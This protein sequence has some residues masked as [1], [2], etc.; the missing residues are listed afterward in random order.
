[1]ESICGN[2]NQLLRRMTQEAIR[3]P[4]N[5]AFPYGKALALAKLEKHEEALAAFQQA[6]QLPLIIR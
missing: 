2:P 1:M 4:K 3:D 5:A 6:A